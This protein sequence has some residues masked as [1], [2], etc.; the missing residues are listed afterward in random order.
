MIKKIVFAALV[1]LTA[2]GAS[3][4]MT[5]GEKSLG[6]KAGYISHNKSAV[7]GLVFQYS[8]SSKFRLSPEIG[9]AFRH[10]NEDALLVDL[11][12]HMPFNLGAGDRV[13]LYPLAG[14]AFNSWA[15]HKVNAELDEADVTTHI[16]RFGANVGAGFDLRCSSNLKLNIEAKYTFIKSYSSV[17]VTAGISYVF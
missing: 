6:P 7:A 12:L 1:V 14:I 9:C 13:D 3:A 10:H 17:V 8:L 15:T 2:F 4:Q 16:N 11:N 5:R